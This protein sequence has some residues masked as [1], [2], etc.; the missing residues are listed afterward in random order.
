MYFLWLLVHG[1]A[2]AVFGGSAAGCAGCVGSFGTF[3]A[4]F[5]SQ[6]LLVGGIGICFFG[7]GGALG[8]FRPSFGVFCFGANFGAPDHIFQFADGSSDVFLGGTS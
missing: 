2:F 6:L 3:G 8:L 4:A 7:F 5:G 1:L